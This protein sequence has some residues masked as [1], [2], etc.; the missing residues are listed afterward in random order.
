MELVLSAQQKAKHKLGQSIRVRQSH[1]FTGSFG[2][3]TTTVEALFL[4]NIGTI[5]APHGCPE[6]RA[7]PAVHL[8][9]SSDAQT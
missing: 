4:F 2:T 3:F 6:K 1:S 9:T 7:P 8:L 5:K